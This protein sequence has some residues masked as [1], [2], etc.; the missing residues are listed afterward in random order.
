MDGNQRGH[1]VSGSDGIPWGD[2]AKG[3]IEGLLRG[4]R[5]WF[6]G[7]K[8]EAPAEPIPQPAATPTRGILIIG[9]AGTGKTTL[10]RI[11]SGEFDWLNEDLG[12]YKESVATDRFTLEDDPATEIVVPPGQEHRQDSTWPVLLNSLRTGAYRGVIFVGS[13][14]LHSL[15]MPDYRLHPLYQGD[16]E[17]FLDRVAKAN[18][19]DEAR[20]FGQLVAAVACCP[21]KLWLLTVVTKQ[22]LWASK[23]ADV[24]A[25]YKTGQFAN[26]LPMSGT[27]FRAERL[28]CSLL[29]RT[30]R[31]DNGD[32]LRP[33]E[34]GYD[35][36]QQMA[37]VRRLFDVI[38]SLMKWE[39]E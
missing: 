1:G 26:G 39:G 14:G 24:E 16:K 4:I 34:A 21:T 37:T 15:T 7:K 11:L 23:R 36:E 17:A 9:P 10:A 3:T 5:E 30:W 31:A 28:L 8:N 19:D 27:N 18:R 25:F 2:V 22:D 32:R 13:F 38:R 6:R 33:N 20:S 12:K 29:I 35:Q